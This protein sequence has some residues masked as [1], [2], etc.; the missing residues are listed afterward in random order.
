M[1]T[2]KNGKTLRVAGLLLALVL[3]TSCFVGG[4]FAKYVTKAGG[5]TSEARVAKWGVT[6]EATGDGEVFSDEYKDPTG[7]KT[8]VKAA[9]G[10]TA[11]KV[12]APGTK[13]ENVATITLQGQ[14]EVAVKVDYLAE[15]HLVG[16]NYNTGTNPADAKFYCP[17]IFTI[18]VDGTETKVNGLE[19]NSATELQ[20]NVTSI[21]TNLSKEYEP[22][23]NLG[24]GNGHEVKVSWEWPFEDTTT[25]AKQTDEKDTYL[26]DQAAKGT[27]YAP[28]V[29]FGMSATVTQID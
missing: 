24:I 26:G 19:A 1:K 9:V 2:K 20:T 13:K 21:I 10:A 28:T 6:V 29:T 7:N 3:V 22:N 5:T 18:T 12:V 25:G 4:T 23:T 27:L 15:L 14:P 11:Y 8:T 16:W 17:L